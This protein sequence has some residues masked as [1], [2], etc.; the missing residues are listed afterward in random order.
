M[1]GNKLLIMVRKNMTI[2]NSEH[3]D[4]IWVHYP[5]KTAIKVNIHLI[6]STIIKITI[7]H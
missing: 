5:R 2:T 7:T 4:R 6:S 1:C 3:G